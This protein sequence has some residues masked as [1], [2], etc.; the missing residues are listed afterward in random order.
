VLLRR[1]L[2]GEIAAVCTPAYPRRG[3]AIA[4]PSPVLLAF[5]S[6]AES[7]LALRQS[8]WRWRI[9]GALFA[10]PAIEPTR[11]R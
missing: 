10:G 6:A 1:N 2:R 7:A 4:P 11:P 5:R 9:A 3:R 8:T